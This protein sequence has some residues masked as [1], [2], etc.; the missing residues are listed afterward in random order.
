MDDNAHMSWPEPEALARRFAERRHA[1][2]LTER[3]VAKRAGMA[4]TYLKQLLSTAPDFDPDGLFRIAAAVDLSFRELL[5]GTS[6]PPP[7][8]GAAAPRP[9]LMSL[10]RPECWKLVGHHGVGRVALVPDAV[11]LIIPVNYTVDAQTVVYRTRPGGVADPRRAQTVS[12]EVDRIDDGRRE[13]WSVLIT[14][15]AEPV[16]DAEGTARIA[17]A[18]GAEPWA[19]GARNRWVRVVPV[20]VTGRRIKSDALSE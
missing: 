14:G 4:L 17:A 11:P 18:A 9:V 8:Q 6:R 15:T 19:G 12:F 10:T 13:G 20:S 1:L 16:E 3:D 5:H 2:G 7:G